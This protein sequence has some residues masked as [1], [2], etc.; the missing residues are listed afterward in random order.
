MCR[1]EIIK[2]APPDK[3]CGQAAKAGANKS[4]METALSH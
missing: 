4:R 2:D 3:Q 1:K